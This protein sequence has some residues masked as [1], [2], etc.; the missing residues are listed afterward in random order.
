M[1]EAETESLPDR[2]GAAVLTVAERSGWARVT[3][4]EVALAAD[5]DVHEVLRSHP[6]HEALVDEAF[7]Y[8]DRL[9]LAGRTEA[10]PS[11]PVRDRLFD[12]LMARFEAMKPFRDAIASY[13]R[14]L[15]LRPV[16]G[17]YSALRLGRS[18]AVTLEAAGV[19]ASGLGGYVRIKGLAYTYLWVLRTFVQDDTP[20]LART[21][22]AL[23]KALKTVDDLC[24]MV[25]GFGRG[26]RVKG[27]EASDAG[28]GDGVAS[29]PATATPARTTRPGDE[30][31]MPPDDD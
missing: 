21:M 15:P 5:L 19:S 29:A 18:M 23:D 16:D 9:A 8:T 25:P 12:V 20:D 14:G 4:A 11:E 17:L 3:P 13:L 26:G 6:G 7:R 22:A 2:I 31:E 24:G 27:A 10:D 28:D 30:P 1:P